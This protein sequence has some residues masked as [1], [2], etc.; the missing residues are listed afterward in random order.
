MH[1]EMSI[2]IFGT[3]STNTIPIKPK[4]N[5]LQPILIAVSETGYLTQQKNSEPVI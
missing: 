1:P 4:I 3:I 5:C 2:L